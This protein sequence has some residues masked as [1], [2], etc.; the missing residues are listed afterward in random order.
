[1]KLGWK[2][3]PDGVKEFLQDV[4]GTILTAGLIGAVIV[5]AGG[6]I[7]WGVAAIGHRPGVAGIGVKIVVV[8]AVVA[9]ACAGGNGLISF[10]SG[11]A[12]GIFG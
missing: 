10:F 5:L 12:S 4:A 8:A 11:K 7:T 9:I 6:A 3:L 1:V 2:A